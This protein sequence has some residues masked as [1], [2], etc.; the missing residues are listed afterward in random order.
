MGPDQLW[1]EASL[2]PTYK[3]TIGLRYALGS[4][5]LPAPNQIQI[6][7]YSLVQREHFYLKELHSAF[8]WACDHFASAKLH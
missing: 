5:Q 2:H 7:K 8:I 1:R 6:I 4:Q 3:P